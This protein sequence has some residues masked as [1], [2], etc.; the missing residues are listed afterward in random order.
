MKGERGCDSWVE[1]LGKEKGEMMKAAVCYCNR[2]Q[3]E[4]ENT[5]DW[6]E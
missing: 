6:M 5:R 1:I 3:D 4:K 2:E